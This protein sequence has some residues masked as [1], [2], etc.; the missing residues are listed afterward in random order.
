VPEIDV[1]NAIWKII[2]GRK[3]D[4]VSKRASDRSQNWIRRREI[5][6]ILLTQIIDQK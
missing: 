6:L 3:L 1:K 4:L 5:N 2:I